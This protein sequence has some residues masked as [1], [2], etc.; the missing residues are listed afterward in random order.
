[1][2]PLNTR[3]VRGEQRRLL[4]LFDKLDRKNRDTLIAFAE[5]LAVQAPADEGAV[6]KAPEQPKTIQRPE[7]E[8]VVA[9]IRRL[10]ATYFMLDR[11]NMLNDTASLMGTHIM[12]GRP[13]ADVIDELESVFKTHYDRYLDDWRK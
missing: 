6:Q 12:Q 3:S 7:P 13:A 8:S 4:D 5:F 10:S 9:A 11:K 2:I 1:M